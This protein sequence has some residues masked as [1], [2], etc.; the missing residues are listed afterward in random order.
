MRSQKAEGAETQPG[1]PST[2]PRRARGPHKPRKHLPR[3]QGMGSVQGPLGGQS[4]KD[5]EGGAIAGERSGSGLGLRGDTALG[6]V[7]SPGSAARLT[8]K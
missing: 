8:R 5:P 1:V 3:L 6:W 2:G 7:A 4:A